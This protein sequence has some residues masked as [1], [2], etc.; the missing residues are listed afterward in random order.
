[1]G[2]RRKGTYRELGVNMGKPR[3]KYQA[4][5]G[6]GGPH[7]A[8]VE[9]VGRE[10]PPQSADDRRRSCKVAASVSHSE[11]CTYVPSNAPGVVSENQVNSL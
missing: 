10:H 6:K 7:K 9:R 2:R 8:I 3:R 1:M 4:I 11:L 5:G